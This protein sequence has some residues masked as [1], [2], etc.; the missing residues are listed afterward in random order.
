MG[1]QCVLILLTVNVSKTVN[2]EM[3]LSELIYNSITAM[4]FSAMFTSQ[5]DNTKSRDIHIECSKQFK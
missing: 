4:G 1:L 5:G 3:I 2:E